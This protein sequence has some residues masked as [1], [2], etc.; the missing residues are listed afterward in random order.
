MSNPY[1]RTVYNIGYLGEGKY[2]TYNNEKVTPQYQ[3]WKDMLKRCYSIKE[4]EKYPT[5]K[6]CS[7]CEE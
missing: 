1:D 7:V 4:I 3:T 5:Y 6:K 2:K